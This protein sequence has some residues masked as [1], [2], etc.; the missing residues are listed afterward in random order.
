MVLK[1]A[2]FFVT[3]AKEEV[4]QLAFPKNGCSKSKDFPNLVEN[5]RDT[6]GTCRIKGCANDINRIDNGFTL[7]TSILYKK[8]RFLRRIINVTWYIYW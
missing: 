5:H 6:L 4:I 2:S 3:P 1:F 7:I 8:V